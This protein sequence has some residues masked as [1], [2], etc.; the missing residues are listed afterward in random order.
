MTIQCVL[1]ELTMENKKTSD[2]SEIGV[3]I[4]PKSPMEILEELTYEIVNSKSRPVG[5]APFIPTESEEDVGHILTA[6]I[7]WR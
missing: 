2:D 6:E 7:Q 1:G 5:M 4:F 3:R